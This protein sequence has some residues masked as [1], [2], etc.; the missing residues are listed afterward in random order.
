M[1]ERPI[2]FAG[3]P[4][5]RV[6]AMRRDEAWLAEMLRREDSCF[7]PLHRLEVPV[8][9]MEPGQLF[10]GDRSWLAQAGGDAPTVLL[11][12]WKERAHFA[13]DASA[14][15]S[16][17]RAFDLAGL[18]RFDNLRAVVPRLSIEESAIAAQARSLVDWHQRH[19]FCAVCGAGTEPAGGGTSRRCPSCEAEHFPRTDPVAIVVVTD[20]SRCLLGRSGHFRGN[21]YSALAGFIEPG[22]SIEEAVRREVKEEAGIDV[23]RVRYLSSQPW[24]FPSSLMIG[25][26][27]EA[28]SAEIALEDDALEDARWFERSFIEDVL[29]GRTQ[30]ISVPQPIAIARHLIEAWLAE[31]G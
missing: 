2:A 9:E 11:G 25:C 3:S 10:W 19:R 8:T 7:L 21:M 23:G 18:A 5:D 26:I 28:R 1:S 14:V 6:S 31:T 4:L 16:P 24:P 13:F 27:A 17:E 29:A 22:E 15:S 30:E 12:V 20:G